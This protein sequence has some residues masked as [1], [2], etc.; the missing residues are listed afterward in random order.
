MTLPDTTTRELVATVPKAA[1]LDIHVSI[2]HTEWAD[3]AEIREYVP[4]REIYGRGV[5]IPHTALEEVTI[6]LLSIG[7][8]KPE[9]EPPVPTNPGPAT[10]D[11]PDI[12]EYSG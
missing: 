3:Y 1:D 4:S 5:L 8:N 9:V 11:T 12:G 10:T 6:A 7:T 2:L